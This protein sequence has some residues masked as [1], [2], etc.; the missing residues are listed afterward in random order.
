MLSLALLRWERHRR[1][2]GGFQYR[3]SARAQGQAEQAGALPGAEGG[4]KIEMGVILA[5]FPGAALFAFVIITA[6]W[7]LVS[8]GLSSGAPSD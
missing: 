6:A 4:L 1:A 5:P 7:P 2:Y 8:G 3:P